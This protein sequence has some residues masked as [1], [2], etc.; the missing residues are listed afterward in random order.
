MSDAQRVL[1]VG[2]GWI[3]RQVGL[4]MAVC[5][6]PVSFVDR[7]PAVTAAA[8]AWMQAS[9]GQYIE[10]VLADAAAAQASL[11]SSEPSLQPGSQPS[12]LHRPPQPLTRDVAEGWESRVDFDRP[13]AS[14]VDETQVVLECVPEQIA[15]KRRIL[16]EVSRQFPETVIIASNSSY[17][18]PSTLAAY[19]ESP[20]RY[21]HWHFHVPLNR[22]SIA[23]IS[24]TEATAAWVLEKLQRLTEQ[25]YQYPLRLRHEQPGYVFNWLLQSL[26]R[27]ALELVAKDVVDVADIDRA[28]KAVSGMPIGPFAMMDHIGLDVIEQ[29]LANARWDDAQPVAIDRL[30]D[31]LRE[32]IE[33]GHL[34][35]KTGRG[36]YEHPQG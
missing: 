16:R 32:P 25:I 18:T 33:K 4:R 10:A 12:I 27:S 28:W 1:I 35:V 21:A 31:I 11:P 36:F 19:V 34:G 8:R 29:V 9:A 14:L 6:L 26:L 30:L 24:G 17:F 7:V 5:G 3:G 22:S 23:D 13:L 15:L 20:E 2:A